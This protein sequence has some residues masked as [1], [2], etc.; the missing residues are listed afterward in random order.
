MKQLKMAILVSLA[1]LAGWPFAY[2]QEGFAA[3]PQTPYGRPIS[4]E[5]AKAAAAAAVATA[6]S[7][8]WMMAV[9]IVDTGGHLVYFEKMD[10][11]Q[12]GSVEVAIDKARSA[13]LFRRPTRVFE[14]GVAQGGQGI[15]LLNLRGAVP[16]EGG[17]PII[18]NGELIGG[19]GLSGGSGEQDGVAAQAGAAVIK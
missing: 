18:A 11:T 3:P 5:S 17:I 14:D 2:A 4:L 19:I 16:L 8:G 10:G 9:A 7:N 6:S 12:T 15:R 13:A 1:M